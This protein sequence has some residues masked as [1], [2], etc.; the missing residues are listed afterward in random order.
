MALFSYSE[1]SPTSDRDTVRMLIGD[2]DGMVKTGERRTW[3]FLLTDGE[4]DRALSKCSNDHYAAASLCLRMMAANDMIRNRA[5]SLGQF[6]TTNVAVMYWGQLADDY[7][8]QASISAGAQ[9]AEIA[10]DE[11]AASELELA[12]ALRGEEN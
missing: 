12:K 7:D 9:T 4:I 11:F 2:T 3:S 10:W 1:Q 5:V 8:R 6:S